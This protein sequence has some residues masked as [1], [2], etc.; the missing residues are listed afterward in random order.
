M[1]LPANA[2]AYAFIL[3]AIGLVGSIV[4][5]AMNKT[6]PANLWVVTIGALTGGAGIAIPTPPATPVAP[7]VPGA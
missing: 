4:L 7:Q 1:K 3:A 6:I 2:A 5:A